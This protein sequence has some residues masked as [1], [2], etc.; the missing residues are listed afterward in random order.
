M[1]PIPELSS[2]APLGQSARVW[3]L[4]IWGVLHNGVR[5]YAGAVAACQ[6]FRAQGGHVILVSNSPRPRD[7]VKRQLDSVGV[8][9]DAYDAI[10][11]SGDVSRA[12]IAD[13][14]GKAIYHLGPDRDLA[15][16]DGISVKLMEAEAAAE[17]IVCTGLFDDDK[18]TP[19]D[20]AGRLADLRARN[21]P[22]ICVNPD[23][24][25]ERGGRMIYCAGALAEAYEALG[26]A[27]RYAGKP[28]PPIYAAAE[29]IA[30]HL[31][32]GKIVKAQILAIGDGV[33]T[34][35]QGAATAGIRSVY[36]ASAVHARAG[37]T[38][39]AAAA[40][41]FPDAASAPI[42]VMSALRW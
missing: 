16:Y 28:Y 21:L 9:P 22:M 10:V 14:A 13:Y 2:I 6:T 31:C 37:E 1:P 17:A 24:T 38:L 32:G 20:Y 39:A 30:A 18:E 35:I 40:R 25:V 5:P 11:T 26:G 12:L 27:V 42:A 34:D 36:I 3:F 4:D 29:G 33:R 23:K 41:L 8:A 7:G 15:L 19:A